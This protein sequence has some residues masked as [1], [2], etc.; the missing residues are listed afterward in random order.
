MKRGDVISI[1]GGRHDPVLP[2][3]DNDP[4]KMLA[5]TF[6]PAERDFL[7]LMAT[8]SSME[9]ALNI[10]GLAE[11]RAKDLLDDPDTRDWIR[12]TRSIVEAS[13]MESVVRLRALLPK[14]VAKLSDLIESPNERI[15]LD[16][17]RALLRVF[18]EVATRPNQQTAL[19]A[20]I[21]TPEGISKLKIVASGGEETD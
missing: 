9:A 13:Y 16:A 15:S 11:A 21:Y 8:G 18:F 2:L 5:S 12:R 17:V 4:Y 7:T 10:S 19:T 3:T 1:T 14:A 6:S 20:N